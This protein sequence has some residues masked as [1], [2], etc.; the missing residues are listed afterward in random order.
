MRVCGLGDLHRAEIRMGLQSRFRVEVLGF[1]QK[2]KGTFP[3][4]LPPSKSEGSESRTTTETIEPLS[5]CFAILPSHPS[6]STSYS[7]FVD[8]K[9]SALNPTPWTNLE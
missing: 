9:A 2:R 7:W 8:G 6:F 1:F 3:T 4:Q 5:L